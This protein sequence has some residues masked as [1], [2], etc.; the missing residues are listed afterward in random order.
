MREDIRIGITGPISETNFGD[1]AMFV[2]NLYDLDIKSVTVFSYNKSFS[3]VI[4]KDYCVAYDI[5]AVEVKLYPPKEKCDEQ[6]E[7]KVGFYPFNPPTDTPLDILL[8]IANIDEVRAHIRDIDVLIVNGGGYFNH[9]W[10][11]SLWRSDMLKKIIV[12]MLIAKQEKKKV[13]FMG[14]SFGPFDSSEEFFNYVFNYMRNTI[15]AVRDRMY[16]SVYL[17]RLGI[18]K[19]SINFV[20]DDLFFIN[21]N[22]LSLPLHEMIDIHNI[23][24]YIVLEIYYPLEEIKE[25]IEQLKDFSENIHSKYGLSIVFLPFD[26]QRGGMWQGEYLSTVLRNF[27]LCSLNS[28]GYLPIQDAYHIIKNAEIV[29]CT[30]YHAMVLAVGAEVPVI[31]TIK[32]VCDDH[33]Y[34]FNKNYGL[35]EY[36]FDGLQ[37]NEMDFIRID[38]PSTL[39]HIEENFSDILRVQKELYSSEQYKKN[40]EYLKKI[41]LEHLSRIAPK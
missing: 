20:P 19:N 24:K 21:N 7:A 5:K 16:S 27:Y 40:K 28:V 2:N 35:L 34:Y 9:L 1:Y 41:R 12:P 36:V 8:R 17:S 13:F 37:F 23:G 30:R 38:F 18:K 32:K 6:F 25:Y 22:I 29:L 39:K 14:N 11:N 3:E 10:N 15:Y 4:L 31:N 26:F 33:R